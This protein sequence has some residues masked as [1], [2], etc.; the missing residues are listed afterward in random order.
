MRELCVCVIVWE[1][2]ATEGGGR[3]PEAHNKNKHTKMLGKNRSPLNVAGQRK[4]GKERIGSIPTHFKYLQ[5]ISIR[6][7][8]ENPCCLAVLG[9]P[10]ESPHC[11]WLRSCRCRNSR[12]SRSCISRCACARTLLQVTKLRNIEKRTQKVPSWFHVLSW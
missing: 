6:K 10:P 2:V 7:S 9:S 11:R 3:R 5:I 4:N 12:R 1:R 8:V